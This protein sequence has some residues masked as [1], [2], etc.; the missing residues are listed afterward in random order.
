V[1]VGGLEVEGHPEL[2]GDFK[3]RVAFMRTCIKT[4][5]GTNKYKN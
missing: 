4:N 1:E 5:E 3:A 2:D